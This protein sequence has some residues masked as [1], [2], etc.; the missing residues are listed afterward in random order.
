M[1]EPSYNTELHKV[2]LRVARNAIPPEEFFDPEHQ[3]K[4]RQLRDFRLVRW[5]YSE[6]K[7]ATYEITDSGQ[8]TLDVWDFEHAEIILEAV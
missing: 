6:G 7:P 8:R 4:I 2:L 1:K 3:I 5:Q